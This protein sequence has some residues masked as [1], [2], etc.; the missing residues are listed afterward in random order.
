MTRH[1][2]RRS[3]RRFRSHVEVRG[4][5]GI[6]GLRAHGMR[7]QINGLSAIVQGSFKL[8][9]FS[10][11]LF[12]FCNRNRDRLKILEWD[13]D[14]F[15]LYLKRLERGRFR[16]PEVAQDSRTMSLS[17]EELRLLLGGPGVIQKLKRQE[18]RT[19]SVI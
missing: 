19:G 15:W 6:P 9:P 7:K 4:Q 8:D 5:A 16:W 2:W 12:V 13:G 11:A 17:A 3:S 14:G 18:V 1:C 10:G